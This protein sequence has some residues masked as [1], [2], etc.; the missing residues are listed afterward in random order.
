[1]P[2][3]GHPNFVDLPFFKS[4]KDE[5]NQ[6]MNELLT[7]QKITKIEKQVQKGVEQM[8]TVRYQS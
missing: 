1:M 8:A 2:D 4:Q 7:K 5:K 6:I 3:G